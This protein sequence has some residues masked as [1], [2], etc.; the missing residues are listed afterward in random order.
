MISEHDG[1][2][3][4][5]RDEERRRVIVRTATSDD[6]SDI[7]RFAHRAVHDAYDQL[8]D[9][10]YATALLE[11]WSPDTLAGAIGA[12]LVC[13]AEKEH[14]V[15][16][17][18]EVGV[19][20]GDPVVRKLE[21]DPDLRS[22][23]IDSWLLD[24]AE[25]VA[26]EHGG[27][28]L[29]AGHIA[30]IEDAAR[31]Y[32]RAGFAVIGTDAAKDRR[33]DTVWRARPLFAD[34]EYRTFAE[35]H[36]VQKATDWK[37]LVPAL[38]DA[39]GTLSRDATVVDVGAGS[40]LG[41]VALADATPAEIIALEPDMTMR[42]MLLARIDGAQ[43]L[44]RVTVHAGAV[45]DGLALLPDSVDGVLAG[46]MLGHLNSEER[47]SLLDWTV[48]HLR[49]GGS[50]L[51]TV[52]AAANPAAGEPDERRVGRH[53]YRI[54]HRAPA[55]DAYESFAEVIDGSET[56]RTRLSRGVWRRVTADDVRAGIGDRGQF[57]E[58]APGIVLWRA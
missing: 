40:G 14:Q 9:A 2:S 5:H 13:V 54:T 28:R 44:D 23:R 19:V 49:P 52:S 11:E 56:I 26:L 16:G 57:V 6:I 46:H 25:V 27:V 38:H 41:V 4:H 50:A 17:L 12:G 24:A 58:P 18:V 10:T 48:E 47:Q 36:E 15:V 37:P 32:E 42:S 30:A 7:E 35:F 8:I 51:F 33:L 53:R 45:P 43:I 31:F 29:L 3:E 34:G 39:F 1:E 22:C 55:P 21:V 20:D